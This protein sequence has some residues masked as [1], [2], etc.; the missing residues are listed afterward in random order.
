MD[1]TSVFKDLGV[2]ANQINTNYVL[3]SVKK[4][5]DRV[6]CHSSATNTVYGTSPAQNDIGINNCLIG[7]DV[8]AGLAGKDKLTLIGSQCCKTDGGANVVTDHICIGHDCTPAKIV[9]APIVSI[10]SSTSAL[11]AV[12]ANQNVPADGAVIHIPIAYKGDKY[13]LLAIAVP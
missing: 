6:P 1:Q 7:E 10:G 2:S 9:N 13:Y 11:V 5:N 4:L 8:K 3:K 12:T